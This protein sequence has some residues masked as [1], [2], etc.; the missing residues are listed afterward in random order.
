MGWYELF[1]E[2]PRRIRKALRAVEMNEG[3]ENVLGN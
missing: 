1:S 3:F 2:S